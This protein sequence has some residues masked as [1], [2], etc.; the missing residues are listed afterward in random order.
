MNGDW[1]EM[2]KLVI[3][4]MTEHSKKLDRLHEDLS[5]LKT[6]VAIMSDREDRELNAAKTAATK[7]A[8][9][10][11]ALVSAIVSGMWSYFRD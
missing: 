4:K 9:G 8:T 10:I 5:A 11:G 1:S 6:H 7:Y 3:S 2:Q